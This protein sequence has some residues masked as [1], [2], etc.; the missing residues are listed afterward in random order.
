MIL[1]VWDPAVLKSDAP[2]NF[3][4]MGDNKYTFTLHIQLFGCV[5]VAYSLHVLTES[6][7]CDR[8]CFCFGLVILEQ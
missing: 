2:L 7:S 5:S 3:L 6:L 4:V 1:Q 8:S